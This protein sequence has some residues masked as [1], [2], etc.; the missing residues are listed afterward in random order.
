MTLPK[1]AT[2]GYIR[3]VREDGPMAVVE[4]GSVL[5]YICDSHE[6]MRRV[7][8][9]AIERGDDLA[10]AIDVFKCQRDQA[11][12]WYCENE[13]SQEGSPETAYEVAAQHWPDDADRLFPEGG[14][15]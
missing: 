5:T 15:G 4:D 1:I 8:D 9:A 2:E 12:R 3:R 11:R 7:L 10:N 6:E 14:N 13:A